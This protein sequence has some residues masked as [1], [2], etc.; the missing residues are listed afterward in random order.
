VTNADREHHLGD[1]D[2]NEGAAARDGGSAKHEHSSIDFDAELQLHDEVLRRACRIQ[3]Q[4]RVLDIGCGT[5]R[6]TR[7]AARIAPA[8]S[9]LGVDISAPAIERARELARIEGLRNV[10]F[11][12]DDAQVHPFPPGHF[13]LALSRF[14]TMFFTDP[15]AAFANIGRALRLDGRLVMMV[16]QRHEQNEWSVS[17]D[18]ALRGAEEAT[19]ASNGSDAFSLADRTTVEGILDTAGFRNVTFTDVDEPVYYGQDV[20]AALDWVCGFACTNAL[21]Q[22]MDQAS[23]ARARGRLSDMLTARANDQGVWFDSRAWIV[24]ANRR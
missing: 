12:R 10:T 21:L 2:R 1:A 13:D 7:D 16:W 15:L 17:I 4:D 19:V 18:R 22:R 14:G 11:E 8:G 5:G 9:A 24:S 3:R 6:T 20:T 23:A